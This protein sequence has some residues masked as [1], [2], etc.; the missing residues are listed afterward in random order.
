M[1]SAGLAQIVEER[2]FQFCSINMNVL[3]TI[4]VNFHNTSN[5]YAF[6]R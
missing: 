6:N 3:Y 1:K 5:E 4:H 2:K